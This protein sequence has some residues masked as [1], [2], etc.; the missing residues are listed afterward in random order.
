ML[1]LTISNSS[2]IKT[3]IIY[4]KS[5]KLCLSFFCSNYI[6]SS[7]TKTDGT[8]FEWVCDCECIILINWSSSSY[9][10]S[11]FKDRSINQLLLLY[12]SILLKLNKNLFLFK[13]LKVRLLFEN[14]IKNE[15]VTNYFSD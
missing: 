9:K 8:S 5:K 2:L 6:L 13:N 14:E 10:N 3:F 11:S 12:A 15:Q 7:Y 1:I 4:G